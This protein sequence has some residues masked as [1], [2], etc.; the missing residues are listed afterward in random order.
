MFKYKNL[1]YNMQG[2]HLQ[3]S[4]HAGI[5]KLT[6]HTSASSECHYLTILSSFQ[7]LF[8][9]LT[10]T[11]LT[12]VSLKISISHSKNMLNQRNYSSPRCIINVV[13][14]SAGKRNLRLP[15]P[16]LPLSPAL[17]SATQQSPGEQ[18]ELWKHKYNYSIKTLKSLPSV[19]WQLP[20][21]ISHQ[22]SPSST[23]S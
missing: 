19:V 11:E 21:L 4:P 5:H 14:Y 2:L 7:N 23:N 13:T 18:S 17:S 12:T 16:L 9:F 6:F 8:Y 10:Q 22:R 20:A 15:S 3:P 1:E